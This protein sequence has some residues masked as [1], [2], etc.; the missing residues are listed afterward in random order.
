MEQK[1]DDKLYLQYGMNSYM[2]EWF[3]GRRRPK[4]GVSL[5]YEDS[6]SSNNFLLKGKRSGFSHRIE[7]G[8]FN[9]LD[10]D[11]NFE[12]L[13]GSDLGT[14]RFRYMAQ[15]QQNFYRKVNKDEQKSF[16][17]DMIS[18]LSA[19]VYGTGDTQVIG[20][21]GPR[22]HTQYKRWMQDIG[23]FASAYEDNTP[24]PVFDAYRYGKE[25]IY[26]REYFRLNRFLTLSWFGSM[27]LSN[28]SPNGKDFQ[29][30]AFYVSVGPDDLKFSIGYDFV[31]QNMYCIVE[32]MMDGKGAR[33]DYDK[34]EIKQ[35][36]KAKKTVNPKD[37]PAFAAPTAPRV[38]DRAI[39]ENVKVHEDVL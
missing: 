39:V 13:R 23:Y 12:R 17:L 24:M 4:Y 19:A 30:N 3:M 35:D 26:I 27:V 22:I 25:N 16:S 38:L 36:K 20:R 8:Y 32:V 5:V 37:E 14:T 7:G 31:R 28:D 33:V 11:R 10:F 2:N 29:E 6:Y 15:A 34:L 18:Q 1:L 21:I 9:D